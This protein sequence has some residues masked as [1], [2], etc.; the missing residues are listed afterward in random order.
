MEDIKRV[1]LNGLCDYEHLCNVVLDPVQH[2]IAYKGKLSELMNLSG[3]SEEEAVYCLRNNPIE[4]ELY[5]SPNLGL[6]AVESDAVSNGATIYDP[7]TGAR[8]EDYV[9]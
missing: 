9:M 8:C 3:M 5:Y 6:F 4:M 2:P 1:K 7:Y